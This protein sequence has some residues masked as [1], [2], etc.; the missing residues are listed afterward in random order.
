LSV[1]LTTA[2][3]DGL[4]DDFEILARKA[5]WNVE[6]RCNQIGFLDVLCQLKE[7]SSRNSPSLVW[8]QFV[9]DKFTSRNH[10]TQIT[11]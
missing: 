11:D 10:R 9:R 8:F 6:F 2:M 1:L 7:P 5:V 3:M 4:R